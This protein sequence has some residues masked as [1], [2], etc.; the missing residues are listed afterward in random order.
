MMENSSHNIQ[1]YEQHR[2]EIPNV[3]I[4]RQTNSGE[5][6]RYVYLQWSMIIGMYQMYFRV[7]FPDL[8]NSKAFVCS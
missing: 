6:R 8:I 2:R 3:V 1:Q 7:F 4:L 5:N